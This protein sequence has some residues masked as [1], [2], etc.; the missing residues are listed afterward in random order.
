MGSSCSTKSSK[1]TKQL[2]VV[3]YYAMK[4]AT[5]LF[6]FGVIADCQYADADTPKQMPQRFYREAAGKLEEAVEHLNNEDLAFTVHLGD[7]IDKDF[8]SFDKVGPIYDKLKAP[9]Y[10][11]LG[12]HDYDVDDADK[13]KVPGRMGLKERYYAFNEQGWRFVV[14]DGNE[15]SVLA[16]PKDSENYKAG[17]AYRQKFDDPPPVWSGGIGEEQI[18]WL[19][20]QLDEA[21]K[22]KESVIVFCHYPVFPD[23][24]HN[25]WNHA[26]LVQVMTKHKDTVV[27]WMNG[28]NHAGNYGEKDG[29]HYLN[30]KGMLDTRLNAYAT[31]DVYPDKTIRIVGYGRE[32]DRLLD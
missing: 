8:V 11:V 29:V 26:E 20:S 21:A 17:E 23:D 1:I 19:E 31:V 24:V 30:F 15:V 16:Y 9:H 4:D 7:F 28:H 2:G 22:A 5:P 14:L 25:L 18:A 32:Q 10:H 12:N 3:P 27:A 6:R 13:A